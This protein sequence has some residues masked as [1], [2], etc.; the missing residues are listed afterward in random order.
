[1]KG[2]NKDLMFMGGMCILWALVV[3]MLCDYSDRQFN[4]TGVYDESS[5]D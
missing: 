4:W 3:F 5:S 1:M 2:I